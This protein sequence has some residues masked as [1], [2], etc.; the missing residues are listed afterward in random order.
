MLLIGFF[1]LTGGLVW[2]QVLRADQ[3][4]GRAGNPRVAEAGSRTH[5]G[6]IFAAD[7][8]VLV[9]SRPDGSGR[10]ERVYHARSLA[11]VL[12]YVS[13]R[14]GVTGVEEAANDYLSGVRG[15]GAL[16]E[17]W[18]D[19]TRD[20]PRGSDIVLTINPA[21]QAAAAAALGDRP[22][23]VV[24]LDPRTGAVL[25]MVSRPDF[26]PAA[27]DDAG[28]ALLADGGRPL[29]NR[30]TQGQYSPGSTFKTVTAAAVLDSG[31]VKA[32]ERF[33]C[34]SGYVVEGFVI[35][36]R[37]LPPG[38]RDYDFAHAYAWS[39]N[40][41][42]A[43][44]A[45]KLGGTDMVRVARRFGFEEELPFALPLATS[46]LLARGNSFNDVLLANT[47][48]GQG[49]IVV[50]PMQM[51]LVAATIANDGTLMQPYLI[52]QA[53]RP[54]GEVLFEHQPQ[55]TRRVV[56]AETA[57]TLRSFM[58]T[59]VREGFGGSAAIAGVEVGGKTGTAE[60]GGGQQTHAWFT[61]IAPVA[62]ARVV[63]AVIVENAGQ[64]S[65]V[66]APVA[67]AVMKAAL[68]R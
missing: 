2:W 52:Q 1:A 65:A 64:G 30:A 10:M 26:D 17:I 31:A 42:F 24:A 3:L 61:G 41:T 50:T 68:G 34:T 59:A 63:V 29:I 32:D 44:L 8:T 7:G 60:I 11:H 51:A 49:Q 27:I 12:G 21:V 37:N 6:S 48:F 5:R 14:Y 13:P 67:Q 36:C 4:A 56:T 45:V 9:E 54:D 39:I 38:T 40:A 66:A 28:A 55:P 57:A 25:A 35:A 18:G 16:T 46:R 62:D 43:E 23:A 58:A 20:P 15:R 47:G 33:R 22:G 53:R 19:I